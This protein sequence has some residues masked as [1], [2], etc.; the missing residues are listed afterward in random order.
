MSGLLRQIAVELPGE[1]KLQQLAQS[2]GV[3]LDLQFCRSF[4]HSGM[5]LLF[6]MNG[7]AQQLRAFLAGL[8]KVEGVRHVY[9]NEIAPTRVLTLVVLNRPIPCSASLDTP[10]VCLQCPFSSKDNP[11]T[12][13]LLVRNS[14]DLRDILRRLEKAG[15]KPV[16]KEIS[17]VSQRE[18]LTDRQKAILSIAVSMGYFDFPRK[19]SLTAL[20][21]AVGVKPSTLSEILRNAER[22][23]LESQVQG[24]NGSGPKHAPVPTLA[25]LTSHS[26]S[27]LPGAL[28]ASKTCSD[29]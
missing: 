3:Q 15:R 21:K 23:V 8:H 4:N 11:P 13:K 9:E 10:I 27:W 26:G 7:E 20:S 25:Q 22:K 28:D 2:M 14:E 12:W 19:V 6:E 17:D 5:T 1:N 24:G 18:E 29:S 16:I